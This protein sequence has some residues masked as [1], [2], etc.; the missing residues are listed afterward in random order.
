MPVPSPWAGSRIS[1]EAS[2][3]DLTPSFENADER[4]LFTV[5]SV[6]KSLRAISPFE[7]PMTTIARVC[8]SRVD[9]AGF[10]DS[11]QISRGMTTWPRANCRECRGQT[12]GRR[13]PGRTMALAPDVTRFRTSRNDGASATTAIGDRSADVT[14]ERGRGRAGSRPRGRR[15]R[16]RP[17]QRARLRPRPSWR[18]VRS[19]PPQPRASAAR[20]TRAGAVGDDKD[21]HAVAGPRAGGDPRSARAYSHVLDHAVTLLPPRVGQYWRKPGL[22]TYAW[23]VPHSARPLDA[24]ER[25]ARQPDAPE[26]RPRPP[27]HRARS[28]GGR[29]ACRRAGPRQRARWAGCMTRMITLR[30]LSARGRSVVSRGGPS[31]TRRRDRRR[32]AK[33][34]AFRPRTPVRR[35]GSSTPTWA[36]GPRAIQ[37]DLSGLPAHRA[38]PGSPR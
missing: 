17:H 22:K 25:G 2:V 37:R 3:R 24:D 27:G 29:G 8:F 9:S 20:R 10:V 33:T 32:A 36:L 21:M 35:R 23:S 19:S 30:H 18:D 14:D 15:A 16:R 34:R 4:W 11:S 28:A 5:A 26:S 38:G 13:R 6:T 12:G 7:K 1:A 31:G